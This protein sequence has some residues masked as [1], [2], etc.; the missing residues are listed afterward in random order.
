MMTTSPRLA[1]GLVAVHLAVNLIHGA[2]HSGAD[3][4]IT[5]LQNAFVWIV[6]LIG[7]LVAV[8]LMRS[9]RR[10]GAELLALTMGG[11]LIFGLVNHFVVDSVDHVSRV[12][13]ET[14]RLPF[15]LSA[16]LLL[17]LEAA[18]VWIGGTAIVAKQ[19]PSRQTV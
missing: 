15:Q 18:G 9:N 2:A 3:V 14:W 10:F 6:I 16:A 19:P 12:T 1:T 8:W 11:A 4:P 17:F 13:N 5:V 7:P